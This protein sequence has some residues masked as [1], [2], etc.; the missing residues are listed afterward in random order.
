MGGRAAAGARAGGARR[1]DVGRDVLRLGA[2]DARGGRGGLQPGRLPPRHRLAARHRDDRVRAAQVR[3]RRR[4]RARSSRRCWRRRRT[5]RPTGCRSCSPASRARSSRRRSPTRS[6]ASRRPG[7]R[8]RSRTWSPP[9]SGSC[10]TRWS[11]GCASAGRRCRAGSSAS[12]CA[13]LRV[14]DARVDL[15][16]ER[17]ARA[18]RWRSPTRGSTA[19]SRSCSRSR[20]R[21]RRAAGATDARPSRA[22]APSGRRPSRPGRGWRPGPARA[23]RPR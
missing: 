7:R 17:A 3:L 9:A 8:A 12:R 15:L 18:S 20:A 10:P 6:P 23:R 2:A 19:T 1:A 14:A 11:G 4:L 16:F 13:G 5:R 22:R 21:G